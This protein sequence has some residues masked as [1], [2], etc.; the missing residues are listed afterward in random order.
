MLEV[1]KR[2]VRIVL[3]AT[4]ALLI[5]PLSMSAQQSPRP[6]LRHP[7]NFAVSPPLGELAKLPPPL[8]YGFREGP[9]VLR[10]PKNP[11]GPVVD[12]LE[13]ASPAS[14]SNFSIGLNFLGLGNG[15]PNF[16][17]SSAPPD[18]SMAVGDTQVV[19]WTNPVFAVF[20]K[21]SG[22]ILAGPILGNTIWSSLPGPVR[23]PHCRHRTHCPI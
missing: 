1:I 17:P 3:L 7:E 15:F 12:S 8:R 20:D 13:Q 21:S 5:C 6:I 19:Q 16:T 18:T 4:S 2:P 14:G 23:R 11:S 22:Q 9:P 10:I